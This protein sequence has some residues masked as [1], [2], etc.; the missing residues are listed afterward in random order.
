MMPCLS[1]ALRSRKTSGIC[2]GSS[3]PY[4]RHRKALRIVAVAVLDREIVGRMRLLKAD[5]Q[6]ERIA[7][8]F[9]QELAGVLHGPRAPHARFEPREGKFVG[10]QPDARRILEGSP[11][12]LGANVRG[13]VPRPN[14]LK[15][16]ALVMS[17]VQAI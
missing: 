12:G 4:L 14:F 11:L 10:V 13:H 16:G 17:S 3:G 1:A 8:M 5:P 7:A 15:P 2:E 9:R 6:C